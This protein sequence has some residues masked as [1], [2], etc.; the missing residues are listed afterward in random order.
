IVKLLTA[1]GAR[2][3]PRPVVSVDAKTLQ[4]YAGAYADQEQDQVEIACEKGNLVYKS[5]YLWATL[6]PI[7][8]T[9][10]DLIGVQDT[11]LSF[12][13]DK[14]QVVGFTYRARTDTSTYN[15]LRKM[16]Q[17]LDRGTKATAEKP[18]KVAGPKHWPSFRG[19]NAIGVADGQ[20]PPT[21]WD[22]NQ[23]T[24]IL[25]KT[26]IPG[27]GHSSPIV[28]KDRIFLTTAVPSNPKVTLK[29]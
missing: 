15:R 19:A 22:V 17:G 21:S 2:G 25:W 10:F 20:M 29:T 26:P 23:G 12:L 1:A 24:N 18:V 5:T 11:T 16:A 28:W 8:Q 14:R 4:S 9:S 3:T 13:T 6:E 27:L 7:N